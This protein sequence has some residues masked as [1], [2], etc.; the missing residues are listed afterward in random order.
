MTASHPV[1]PHGRAPLDGWVRDIRT[2]TSRC[3]GAAIQ[4]ARGLPHISAAVGEIGELDQNPAVRLCTGLPVAL[5]QCR[6]DRWGTVVDAL[7]RP[8]PPPGVSM[9]SRPSSR[10][11]T[12]LARRARRTTLRAGRLKGRARRHCRACRA[13]SCR[14]RPIRVRARRST[15]RLGRSCCGQTPTAAAGHPA[16]ERPDGGRTRCTRRRPDRRRGRADRATGDGIIHSAYLGSA[17]EAA[18]M[19]MKPRPSAERRRPRKET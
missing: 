9:T 15:S 12:S 4:S 10:R 8:D 11:W 2:N 14:S 7:Q 3:G 17:V 16:S 13:T 6:L 5:V 19:I 1:L 18:G